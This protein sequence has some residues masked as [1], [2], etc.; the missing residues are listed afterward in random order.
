MSSECE[1]QPG[2]MWIPK[3]HTW[4][5]RNRAVEG[6]RSWETCTSIRTSPSPSAPD[7]P[8]AAERA[9][10]RAPTPADGFDALLTNMRAGDDGAFAVLWR[11]CNPSLLRY[12]RVV[13]DEVADDLAAETWLEVV[14][15]LDRFDGDERGF[16]AWLFTIARHRFLDWCRARARN[17]QMPDDVSALEHRLHPPEDPADVAV[18]AD[19]T[20]HALRLIGRLPPEQAEVV[21]L[22]VIA[23]LDVPRVA[24]IVRKRP[25]TVRVLAHRG[26]RNLAKHVTRNKVTDEM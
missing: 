25:G 8:P 9:F 3:E 15:G 4:S 2:G 12:L 14:R 6:R 19:G 7:A 1:T 5:S 22:R 20:D 16:R 26:L 23:D 24:R 11:A 17:P 13:A 10:S 18:A 21:A